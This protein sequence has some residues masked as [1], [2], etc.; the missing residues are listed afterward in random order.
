LPVRLSV[1]LSPHCYRTYACLAAKALWSNMEDWRNTISV[2][3]KCDHSA[4]W[5]LPESCTL[6]Y[7]LLHPA[8]HIMGQT[9]LNGS[10]RPMPAANSSHGSSLSI[11]PKL[12]TS[13]NWYR[14]GRRRLVF[15]SSS[16]LGPY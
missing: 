3:M 8:A 5:G 14:G 2:I 12:V 9:P 7:A 1:R 10:I 16:I 15:F 13:T 6:I 11:G 4:K